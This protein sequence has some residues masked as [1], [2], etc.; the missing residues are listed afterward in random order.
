[1]WRI[2]EK[3]NGSEDEDDKKTQIKI[4]SNYKILKRQLA[5]SRK[6]LMAGA[7]A[8]KVSCPTNRKTMMMK[9]M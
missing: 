4:T 1:M 6:N 2:G 8:K 5:I 3:F 7:M 9:L